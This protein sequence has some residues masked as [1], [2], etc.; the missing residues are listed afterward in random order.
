MGRLLEPWIGTLIPDLQMDWACACFVT[1][2][3]VAVDSTFVVFGDI[4]A[5]SCNCFIAFAE[6]W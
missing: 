4:L 1:R 3:L 5:L 2:W 6:V